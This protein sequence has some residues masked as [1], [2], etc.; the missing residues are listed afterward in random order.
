MTAES[1]AKA[2]GVGR[3]RESLDLQHWHGIIR[4]RP[5]QRQGQDG[6]SLAMRK[7]KRTYNV[8]RI[9]AT[10]PYSVQEI[11]ELFGIHKNAVLR[12]IKDGLQAN[13][14]QRPFLIRGEELIRFLN[15]RQTR[16]RC[17]CKATEFYC[18][19]CRAPREAYLGI[20][21]IAIESPTRLRVR[22]LCAMC[23]TP[24]NKV[25]SIR[26]LAKIQIRF[27]VQQLT[28]ERILDRTHASLNSDLET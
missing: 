5:Q 23:S 9:K 21:D 12:W 19:R 20:A 14:D 4:K 13:K 3:S 8:G 1:I 10:W 24:I 27:H 17:K 28:G 2:L 11:A 25:Q 22:S 15:A 7:C 26:D 18:F 16:K 6:M